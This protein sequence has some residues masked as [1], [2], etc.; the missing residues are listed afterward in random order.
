MT[1]TLG[2]GIIMDAII[3]GGL[4]IIIVQ[5]G[6]IIILLIPRTEEEPIPPQPNAATDSHPPNQLPTSIY[7][8]RSRIR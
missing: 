2:R 4:L 7:P 6:C 8:I 5:L 1:T 3:F